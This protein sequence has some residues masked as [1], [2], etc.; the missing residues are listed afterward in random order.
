[1]GYGY[2]RR[3]DYRNAYGAYEATADGAVEARLAERCKKNMAR[4]ER[5]QGNPDTVIGFSRPGMD[6]DKTPFYPPVQASPS[7]LPISDS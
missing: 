3:G 4:I 6:N 5:K 7:E 1:M 2:L